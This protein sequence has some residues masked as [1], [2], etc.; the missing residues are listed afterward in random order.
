M[1]WILTTLFVVTVSGQAPELR[2]EGH[3]WQEHVT[4]NALG[5]LSANDAIQPW[6]MP[7]VLGTGSAGAIDYMGVAKK[8][9]VEA[10]LTW[11]NPTVPT[12][13]NPVIFDYD[14]KR[15]WMVVARLDASD[16]THGS[17]RGCGEF[18]KSRPLWVS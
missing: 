10:A 13:D 5:Y 11:R 1:R 8:S 3:L 18:G 7:D 12:A 4:G 17:G 16:A 2:A 15:A 6:H 9:A 14:A